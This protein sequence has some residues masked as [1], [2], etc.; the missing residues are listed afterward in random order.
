MTDMRKYAGSATFI[1]FEDCETPI[2]SVIMEVKEGKFGKPDLILESGDKF[3]V[4]ATNAKILIKAYGPDDGDWL[5]Q[6]IRLVQGKT[7]YQGNLTDSVI[8]QPLSPGR[9]EE[10][11]TKPSPAN[12]HQG[13]TEMDDEIPF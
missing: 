6:R 9:P 12:H 13:D 8:I 11:R 1:K 3:S 4:N 5:S 10:Q 7:K 2:E